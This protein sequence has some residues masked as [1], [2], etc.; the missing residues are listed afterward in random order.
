MRDVIFIENDQ[1]LVKALPENQESF[2]LSHYILNQSS[3]K[4]SII[5]QNNS[6]PTKEIIDIS[7]DNSEISSVY[8]NIET[9]SR[10]F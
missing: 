1:L 6:S 9:S 5:S 3:S 4:P 10:R 8:S 7:D 2:Y